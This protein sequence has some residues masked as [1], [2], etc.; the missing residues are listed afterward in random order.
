MEKSERINELVQQKLAEIL[1]RRLPLDGYMITVTGA[2]ISPDQKRLLAYVSVLP[3]RYNGTALSEL[4]K[5]GPSLKGEL[6]RATKL[7]E[8]PKIHWQIDNTEMKAAELEEV[9]R[10]I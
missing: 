10:Q 5:I 1:N 6:A 3:D 4:R 8:T 2:S 7:R 9:F